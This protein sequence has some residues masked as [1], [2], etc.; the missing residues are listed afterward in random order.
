MS[1]VPPSRRGDA[2]ARGRSLGDARFCRNWQKSFKAAAFD[3]GS[4]RASFHPPLA[5][6]PD[7]STPR[8]STRPMEPIRRYPPEAVSPRQSVPELVLPRNPQQKKNLSVT[9]PVDSS[10]APPDPPIRREYLSHFTN[11]QL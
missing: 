7:R 11:R 4:Y 3:G 8:C 1:R 10:A 9:A 2:G 5:S 6:L